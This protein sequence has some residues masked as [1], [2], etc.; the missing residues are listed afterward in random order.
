MDI[1]RTSQA[2]ARSKFEVSE[3]M[4]LGTTSVSLDREDPFPFVTIPDFEVQASK[5]LELSDTDLLAYV[6]LVSL[7]LRSQWETYA[8]ENQGWLRESLDVVGLTDV[9]PGLVPPRIY[10]TRDLD[11]PDHNEGRHPE[12]RLKMAPLW[13]VAKGKLI[14][15]QEEQASRAQ[16][17][18][19]LLFVIFFPM[20]RQVS[21]PP[22]D[23]RVMNL[24]MLVE[25]TLAR[26]LGNIIDFR[27]SVISEITNPF[28]SPE[29][30]DGAP[31]FLT[32]QEMQVQLDEA[33][34]SFILTPV[35]ESFE[36]G[37]NVA[38]F[39]IITVPWQRYFANLLPLGKNGVEVVLNDSCGSVFT[40][41]LNGPSSSIK[42]VGDLHDTTY[43]S[44]GLGWAY[45]DSFRTMIKSADY[46]PANPDPANQ[47]VYRLYAYPTDEFKSTYTTDNPRNYAI[48]VSMIFVFT[49][50]VF[51]GYDWAVARRQKK[52]LR[53]ATR[54]QAIVASLFPEN[55]QERILQEAEEES[56]PI[57][58]RFRGNRTKDQLRN[59]LS[60]EEPGAST[61][62]GL[63]SKPIADLF[64]EATVIFAE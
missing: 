7:P 61:K 10:G 54:T 56:A 4:A 38:A 41:L 59:F 20:N 40:F 39:F 33:A 29:L 25:N 63:K 17:L 34:Q 16:L 60:D 19:F 3:S 48:A 32:E 1:A 8:Q 22:Q 52:V 62:I 42:G 37:A 64:P 11:D 9:D 15:R 51:L 53:T 45:L 46:D 50:V 55:V 23:A 31:E 2:S 5:S 35:F 28:G 58:S 49:A 12:L 13:Y 30:A 14:F 27:L 57:V 43:D 6:P 36:D 24:D 44:Q 18:T 21:A 47:C 26:L